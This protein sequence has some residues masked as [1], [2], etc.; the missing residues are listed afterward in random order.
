MERIVLATLRWDTAAVTP[1]DFLPH[2]VTSV[3]SV[4]QRDG[5]DQEEEE[6]EEERLSTVRR[7]SD[8][9]AAMCVC[10]SRFL[11]A[12]PSLVAAAA[13]NCALRG[14]GSTSPAQ[15]GLM[16]EALAEL[17]Q[18]DPVSVESEELE[19]QQR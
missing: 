4:A 18:T 1:Q 16:C 12:A 11:G 6:E 14:L 7:H 8:T 3:A 13:L 10:D 5:G 15:L 9:L 2:F 19:L 17:C